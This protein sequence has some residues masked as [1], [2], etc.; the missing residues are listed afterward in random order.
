M[1]EP[2]SGS[3]QKPLHKE[4]EHW[5][6]ENTDTHLLFLSLVG[7]FFEGD[8]PLPWRLELLQAACDT[9]VSILGQGLA[10]TAVHHNPCTRAL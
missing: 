8:A 10:G 6:T 4:R 5:K 7:R 3:I 9:S 2:A 1:L